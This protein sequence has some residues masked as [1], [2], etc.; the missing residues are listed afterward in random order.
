MMHADIYIVLLQSCINFNNIVIE[1]YGFDTIST[2]LFNNK[3]GTQSIGLL[4]FTSFFFVPFFSF[5]KNL[6]IFN[7]EINIKSRVFFYFSV[8]NIIF[9]L[10][11]IITTRT[12]FLIHSF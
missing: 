10:V 9:W 3:Y 5:K 7:V 12:E 8:F 1:I 11:T 2:F 6:L 4:I